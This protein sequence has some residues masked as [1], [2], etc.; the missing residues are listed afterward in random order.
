MKD[1][2]K[3]F[4][5]SVAEQCSHLSYCDKKKVGAVVVKDNSIISYGYNGTL[6]GDEN[7]CEIEGVTKSNVVHA[8]ANAI[9]KVARSTHSC[10]EASMFITLAPCMECTKLIIQSGIKEVYYQETYRDNEGIQRLINHGI[11][12]EKLDGKK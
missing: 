12:V 10:N 9:S 5:M 3:H 4:Y 1:K 8:E 7:I 11:K 2:F 6:P